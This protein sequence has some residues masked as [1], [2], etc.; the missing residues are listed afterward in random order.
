[1]PSFFPEKFM[2]KH[3]SLP[4]L[5]ILFLQPAA[6]AQGEARL[7]RFPAIHGNQLVFTYASDLYTVDAQGG[8]AAQFTSHA[9]F[10]MFARFSPD[11]KWIAFTVQYP[12]NPDAY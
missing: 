4:L 1:M 6:H 5:L 3:L 9:G 10:E 8:V 12:L 11:G 7:L 2:F